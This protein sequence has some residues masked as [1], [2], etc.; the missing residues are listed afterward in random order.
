MKTLPDEIFASLIFMSTPD[1]GT[2]GKPSL[3]PISALVLLEY[4]LAE[5]VIDVAVNIAL[6][7][8]AS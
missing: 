1:V 2:L 4:S 6:T 8:T 5:L 7:L 3:I